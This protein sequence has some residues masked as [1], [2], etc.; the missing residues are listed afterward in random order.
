[1]HS[2]RT[3]Q[4]AKT[5]YVIMSVLLCALGVI[6]MVCPEMSVYVVCRITGIVMCVYGAVKIIG[7]FS[8]DL[9]RLA[10]QFDLAYGL[11]IMVVG[12]AMLIFTNNITSIFGVVLGVIIL[13]DA[14]FK[15]QIT[16]DSKKFGIK[17]WWLIAVFAV[18]TA[19]AGV[20]LIAVSKNFDAFTMALAGAALVCEGILSFCVVILAV[21]IVHNQLPEQDN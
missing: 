13:T 14:L 6:L 7:Y 12:A 16:I 9:Y 20:W 10:F 18:I 8:R 15:V 5:G 3:I 1:M 19:A 2:V 4:T 21:K 11:L 17:T